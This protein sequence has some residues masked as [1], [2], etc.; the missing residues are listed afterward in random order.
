MLTT[1]IS[2]RWWQMCARQVPRGTGGVNV[3]HGTPPLPKNKRCGTKKWKYK[4][5]Y[6]WY[7]ETRHSG[8][9]TRYW[10]QDS[11]FQLNFSL[12]ELT[13]DH[14]P[15]AYIIFFFNCGH[16]CCLVIWLMFS[17]FTMFSMFSMLSM[18]SQLTPCSPNLLHVFPTYSMFSL[19][20]WQ[21]PWLKVAIWKALL[22]FTSKYILVGIYVETST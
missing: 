14:V 5:K 13:Q 1:D 11:T 22:Y 19:A 6:K 4:Y 16:K 9:N 7:N 10:R 3:R 21:E 15:S 8:G 18:F 12:F 2:A 20:G 17:I